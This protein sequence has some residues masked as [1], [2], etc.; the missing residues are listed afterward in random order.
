M[1]NF[2]ETANFLWTIAELLRDTFKRSKYQDVILP[3]TVLRRIDCVLEPTKDKVLATHAKLK[4]KGLA[5][6]APQL[7]KASGYAFYNTSPFTFERL[8]ADAPNL[9]A[10]LRAY[11]AGFSDNMQ[12]AGKVRVSQHHRQARRGGFALSGDGAMQVH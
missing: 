11:I 10:N 12:S 2:S 6:L 1:K 9:A 4:A 8:L 3:F 7:C 5:N